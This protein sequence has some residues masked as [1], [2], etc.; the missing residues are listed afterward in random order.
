MQCVVESG[1]L[2][3]PSS[4]S[5]CPGW[6]LFEPAE[7]AAVVGQITADSVAEIGITPETV[8]GSFLLGFGGVTS[9]VFLAWIVALG[10]LVVR[11]L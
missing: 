6:Y 4:V 9:V 2:I 10:V 7:A 8:S 11:R 1:G 3:V 5:P